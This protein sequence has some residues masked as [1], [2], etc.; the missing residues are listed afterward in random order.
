MNPR[1]ILQVLAL[2]LSFHVAAQD[3]VKLSG[4]IQNRLSDTVLVS[5]NNNKLAYYPNTYVA[6][7]DKKGNF[8]VKFPV[9]AGVYTQA[10]L[11]HGNRVADLLLYAGDSIA[12]QV[13]T[14]NFDSSIRYQ[15]KGSAVQNLVARHT[16]AR[17]RM[18][19]YT[20]KIRAMVEQEPEAFLKNIEAE[21][22]VEM[23]YLEANKNGLPRSF[24]KYWTGFYNYFNY[25]FMEQY[26][27]MHEIAMKK[28]FTDTISEASYAVIAKMPYAFDD[29][30]LQVPSYLLYLTGVFEMKLKAAGYNYSA[31]DTTAFRNVL[32]STYK[33]AYEKLPGKSAEYFIAQSLYGRAK[34]QPIARTKEHFNK[35]KQHWPAS[36]YMP[37]LE[38]QIGIAE[39]TS[40]GMPAP[41]F[42]IVTADG[43]AMKL[44]DLK[45]K[46]VYL[47]F[48][49]SWCRQCVGEMIAEKKTKEFLKR[50]P[51]EF[52]YVSLDRDTTTAGMLLRKYGIEGTFTYLKN[53]WQSK[54]IQLYGVQN[55]PAY[56]LIDKDGNFAVQNP[57]TPRQ[58]TELLLAIGKLY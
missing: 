5:Y 11:Q 16:L 45:G 56:Y 18:N 37:L 2:L 21:R 26:P 17:G 24:I 52:V 54:E 23:A 41:D 27:Q 38:S 20:Q 3:S 15:G 22:N 19:Q 30:M 36:E 12:V 39:R 29:S 1:R 8:S 42:D 9:P 53:E 46:V 58:S 13:N 28:R 55:L 49:A 35:F 50:K 14:K 10:E 4:N 32:D 6:V 48:W 44:S 34:Y 47:H 40:P 51:V 33:L 43:K 25:F 7:L 31:N 57:P